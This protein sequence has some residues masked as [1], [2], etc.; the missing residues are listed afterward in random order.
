MVTIPYGNYAQNDHVLGWDLEFSIRSNIGRKSPSGS[1][2]EMKLVKLFV[3]YILYA[4]E[5]TF[6]LQY[7]QKNNV[8]SS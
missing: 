5:I 2:K 7:A 3:R 8:D 1:R 6:C 4:S